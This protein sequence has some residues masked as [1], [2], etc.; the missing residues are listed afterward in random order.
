MTMAQGSR[1][2]A[3]ASELKRQGALTIYQDLIKDKKVRIFS[4]FYY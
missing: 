4:K 3:Y 1:L 2:R